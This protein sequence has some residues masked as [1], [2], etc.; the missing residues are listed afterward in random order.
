MKKCDHCECEVD[1]VFPYRSLH[2]CEFCLLLGCW[3]TGDSSQE[4]I[5]KAMSRVGNYIIKKLTPREDP[6]EPKP[7]KKRES[8]R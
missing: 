6:V 1:K 5:T 4:H 8:E 3:S 2:V 7:Y